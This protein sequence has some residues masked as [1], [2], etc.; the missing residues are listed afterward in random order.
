MVGVVGVRMALG[1]SRGDIRKVVPG[2]GLRLT[3][4]GLV[5][6]LALAV[7][8]GRIMAAA[9]YGITPFDPVTLGGVLVLLLTVAMVASLVPAERASR[10][11]PAGTLREE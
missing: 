5:A 6:G 8:T 4:V 11:D 9:L 7:A 1:A 10:T 3:A 2:A